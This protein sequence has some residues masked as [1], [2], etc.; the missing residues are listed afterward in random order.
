MD[1][2]LWTLHYWLLHLYPHVVLFLQLCS[3]RLLTPLPLS[4]S[5]MVIVL[6]SDWCCSSS[7]PLSLRI[8]NELL[9]HQI[10]SKSVFWSCSAFLW[11]II[12][13]C[14]FKNVFYFWSLTITP[15]PSAV[16][17]LPY[18]GSMLQPKTRPAWQ[19]RTIIKNRISNELA[20]SKQ[21]K[22]TSVNTVYW[23]YFYLNTGF[24]PSVV[25]SAQ[26]IKC[27]E[28]SF[29]WIRHLVCW[30]AISE[31]NLPCNNVGEQTTFS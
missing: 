13:L 11:S 3:C 9:V 12:T 28:K 29:Y 18:R 8:N 19:L 30:L 6:V 17:L 26:T 24:Y 15:A 7:D 10:V 16:P 5:P 22:C 2:N 25:C 23:I 21:C 1:L 31:P 27:H 20:V 14:S 4:C